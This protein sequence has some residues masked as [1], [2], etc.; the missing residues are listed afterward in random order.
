VQGRGAPMRARHNK[1]KSKRLLL[2]E[3]KHT[4]YD[5]A[6]V[7]SIK[8]AELTEKGAW[9]AVATAVN[10]G[11]HT[12]SPSASAAARNRTASDSGHETTA[13]NRSQHARVTGR[14]VSPRR[15]SAVRRCT[16]GACT[17]DGRP[18]DGP[19]GSATDTRP[20]CSRSAPCTPCPLHTSRHTPIRRSRCPSPAGRACS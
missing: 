10:V 11:L 1:L 2:H 9:A 7:T 14:G 16:S 4:T 8:D 5:V 3:S 18:R 6:R 12:Q 13:A 20:P 15:R 17:L 19:A